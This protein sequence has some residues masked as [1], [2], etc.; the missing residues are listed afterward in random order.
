MKR[1][2]FVIVTICKCVAILLVALAL[3]WISFLVW[4]TVF[5]L[6]VLESSIREMYHTIMWCIQGFTMF[7]T[8]ALALLFRANSGKFWLATKST[9]ELA[10]LQT[11]IGEII[12]EDKGENG[13]RNRP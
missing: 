3:G 9:D 11:R 6:Q 1:W 5:K 10:M 8:L 13:R 4:E 12:K 7:V 2:G